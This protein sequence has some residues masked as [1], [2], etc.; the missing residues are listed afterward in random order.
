[1]IGHPGHELRV[2]GWLEQ[3]RPTVFVL[4]DGSGNE[5]R[6]RL[7][8]TERVLRAVGARSGSIFGRLS[9]RELYQQVLAQDVDLFCGLAEELAACLL[10]EGVAVVVGDAVEGF[11]PA[12][13]L[14]RLVLN[15]AVALARARGLRVRNYD[16]VL[17]AA[18]GECPRELR[19]FASHL[20]LDDAA[21]HR[22]LGAARAYPELV[23][24]VERNL[25]R[26]GEE[27]FREEWL[28]PVT[29]GLSTAH[30]VGPAPFY[31]RY[32]AERVANGAYSQIIRFQQHIEPVAIA[33]ATRVATR[34]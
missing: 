22:K 23:K 18:P 4:T 12:H 31:E 30:L 21:L 17:E 27:A 2:H 25:A 14:T 20:R 8:S 9:D 3:H 5:G 6:S 28:R 19:V 26:L 16:F 15:A 10:R 11:N 33:L 32:G 13:D 1:M 34:V 7:P 24:E 29:Y